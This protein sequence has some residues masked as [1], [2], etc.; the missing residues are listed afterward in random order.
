MALLNFPASPSPGDTYTENN[1]TYEYTSA[2]IWSTAGGDS[3][4]GGYPIPGWNGGGSEPVITSNG[5][6]EAD[7]PASLGVPAWAEYLGNGLKLNDVDGGRVFAYLEENKSPPLKDI[8]LSDGV[9]EVPLIFW[10]YNVRIGR[11]T[12]QLSMNFHGAQQIH[13]NNCVAAGPTNFYVHECEILTGWAFKEIKNGSITG[14][15]LNIGGERLVDVTQC[16]F[17][18]GYKQNLTILNA[19]LNAA[20]VNKVLID[21]K[22]FDE[23][24]KNAPRF[25]GTISLNGGTSAGL[26][27]LT[28]DGQ[29]ALAY[30]TKTGTVNLNP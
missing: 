27:D 16:A 11:S 18:L 21:I 24:R 20:S 4:V 5:V 7:L 25:W 13:G 14:Y 23:Q 2:G 28:A 15:S 8:T 6:L 30:L 29:A 1:I 17:S 26:S 19:N 10:T 12:Q 22:S 9:G 3:G